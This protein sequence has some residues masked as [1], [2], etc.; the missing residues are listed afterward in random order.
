[1]NEIYV[2]KSQSEILA[3]HQRNE[4]NGTNEWF[5]YVGD[6]NGRGHQTLSTRHTLASPWTARSSNIANIGLSCI[7]PDHTHTSSNMQ[8]TAAPDNIGL[9]CKSK[10]HY[11]CYSPKVWSQQLVRTLQINHSDLTLICWHSLI[12]FFKC[13]SSSTDTRRFLHSKHH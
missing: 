11:H 7:T 4:R 8:L 13:H 10:T 12:L 2:I 5:G 6:A 3:Q 9:F 1:M